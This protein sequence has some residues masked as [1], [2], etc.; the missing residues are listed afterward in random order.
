MTKKAWEIGRQVGPGSARVSPRAVRMVRAGR[1]N[2]HAG[3]VCSPDQRI[4]HPFLKCPGA[5]PEDIYSCSAGRD[6]LL[7]RPRWFRRARRLK[8]AAPPKTS[9]GFLV[10]QLLREKR[11]RDVV[12]GVPFADREFG[13]VQPVG[14]ACAGRRRFSGQAVAVNSI[15][16]FVASFGREHGDLQA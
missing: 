5:C 15:T 6:G 8:T 1:P 10:Q 7:G 13:Q 2:R 11:E 4:G 16:P 12:I 14:L 3:R 9:A